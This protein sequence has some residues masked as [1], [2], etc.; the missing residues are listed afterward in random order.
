MVNHCRNYANGTFL[1]SQLRYSTTYNIIC[2]TPFLAGASNCTHLRNSYINSIAMAF[3]LLKFIFI[4]ILLDVLVTPIWWYTAGLMETL[5]KLSRALREGA[6]IIGITIWARSLFKPMY[7]EYSWQGRI[8]SFFMR[9]VVLMFMCIQMI[10]WLCILLVLL[11]IW[12][13]LPVAVVWQI[14]HVFA[15]R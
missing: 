7:G 14:I 6:N 5:Q 3:A 1:R 4:D 8:V 9:C 11:F 13:A 2:L 12:L 10:V 15:L